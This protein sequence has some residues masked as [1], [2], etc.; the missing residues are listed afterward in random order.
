[1]SNGREHTNLPS[2]SAEL[3]CKL[4]PDVA[5]PLPKV[6]QLYLSFYQA[7]EQG[8]LRFDTRLPS[9]RALAQQLDLGRNTVIHVYEQLVAEGLLSADGRRGTRVARQ[10]TRQQNNNVVKLHRS[11]RSRR[12]RSKASWDKDFS[13][14]SPDTSLFPHA[15]WRKAEAN[16]VR[17]AAGEL[18]YRAQALDEAREAVARYLSMYRSL[19]VQPEQIVIT[20]GTRQSLTLAA[21]LFSDPGDTAWLECPGY[22]GAVDAFEQMG[23]NLQPCG[24]DE[25]G[26]VLPS[27]P[28]QP[29]R[30]IYLTPCFQYPFGIPLAAERRQA[31]LALSRKFGTVLFED[32][33]DSEFRDDFQP[34]P[35]LASDANGAHVLNA[36]T[37]S[38]ILFPA[39]RV[40]WLVVPEPIATDAYLSLKAIGGG[41]NTVAQR[42]VTEL[43]NNGSISR[44]L[45]NA[46]QVYRQRRALFISAL[47]GCELLEPV[48]QLSGNLSLVLRLKQS[49]AIDVLEQAFDEHSL[50]VQ[51]LERLDWKIANPKRCKAIVIGLG[52]VDSLSIPA[53]VKRLE[54][55]LMIASLS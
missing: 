5:S 39:I 40:G 32:D 46:R 16:A 7:I 8:D 3:L 38:K 47:E 4:R 6:R 29:P 35:S 1:M 48:H 14:G 42:V 22:S 2:L 12:I 53:A 26:M 31:L 28:Y 30:I 24:V 17:N 41:N 43:L 33:Y 25:Q 11:D 15:I 9:S 36:G 54:A 13:P 37:F 45:R 21:S 51:A 27:M 49:V 44:H 34:R 20:S 18:G 19:Q 50:G 23:L 55:A 10:I 52:N